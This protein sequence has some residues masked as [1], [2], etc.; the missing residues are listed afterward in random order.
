MRRSDDLWDRYPKP[1]K[2]FSNALMMLLVFVIAL[3]P[4]LIMIATGADRSVIGRFIVRTL[5]VTVLGIVGWHSI[6][7]RRWAKGRGLDSKSIQKIMSLPSPDSRFWKRPDIQRLLLPPG[8]AIAA[9][10]S[11]SQTPTGYLQALSD[12]AHKLDGPRRDIAG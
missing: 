12:A 6:R 10:D 1:I 3:L 8:G 7:A 5:G 9:I 11:V 2:S 4:I